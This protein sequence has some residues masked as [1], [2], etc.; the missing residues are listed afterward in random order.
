MDT[1]SEVQKTSPDHGVKSRHRCDQV[2]VTTLGY[3][4]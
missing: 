2:S 4:S 3:G 1:N